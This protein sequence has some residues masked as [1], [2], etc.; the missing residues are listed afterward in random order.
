MCAITVHLRHSSR[1]EGVRGRADV[2]CAH[3]LLRGLL[4][5]LGRGR[6]AINISLY[7]QPCQSMLGVE[8][9]LPQLHFQHAPREQSLQDAHTTHNVMTQAANKHARALRPQAQTQPHTETAHRHTSQH[10]HVQGTASITTRMRTHHVEAVPHL[11]LEQR[12][13]RG[14]LDI[15]HV[16]GVTQELGRGLQR[17]GTKRGDNSTPGTPNEAASRYCHSSPRQTSLPA[18]SFRTM[19]A[20]RTAR[21][22]RRVGRRRMSWGAASNLLNDAKVRATHILDHA[23]T[24]PPQARYE[25]STGRSTRTRNLALHHC[26]RTVKTRMGTP[27]NLNPSQGEANTKRLST[28]KRPTTQALV[29]SPQHATQTRQRDVALTSLGCSSNQ[30]SLSAKIT[31]QCLGGRAHAHSPTARHNHPSSTH[32]FNVLVRAHV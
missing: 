9:S 18:P 16:V 32:T 28:A 29:R 26:Q 21:G 17:R 12:R 5:N 25:H 22:D 24:S 20:G 23:T 10:G 3:R 27:G 31:A 6:S 2:V 15:G 30:V 8:G 13:G 4:G 11:V 19:A 14:A 7:T 1:L